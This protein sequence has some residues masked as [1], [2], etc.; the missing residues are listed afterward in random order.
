MAAGTVAERVTAL[1]TEGDTIYNL[2]LESQLYALTGR[3]PATRMLRLEN[4]VFSP[5]LLDEALAQ[6]EASPPRV[7]IDTSFLVGPS[8]DRM[9]LLDPELK[10]AFASLLRERYELVESVEFAD[11]YRLSE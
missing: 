4:V 11:I 9:S 1:T 5:E 10:E 8:G 7:I 3:R 6:L 2:G